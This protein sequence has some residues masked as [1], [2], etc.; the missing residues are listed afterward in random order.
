MPDLSITDQSSTTH[1]EPLPEEDNYLR[2]LTASPKA[3][4]DSGVHIN[5]SVPSTEESVQPQS[6][7]E[8]D[9]GMTDETENVT[10]RHDILHTR[11]SMTSSLSSS[12]DDSRP[13]QLSQ[14]RQAWPASQGAGINSSEGVSTRGASTQTHRPKQYLVRPSFVLD[15]PEL[16]VTDTTSSDDQ[17]TGGGAT[18]ERRGPAKSRKGE[19]IRLILVYIVSTAYM[20]HSML[21]MSTSLYKCRLTLDPPKFVSYSTL[22]CTRCDF[23]HL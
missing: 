5:S 22:E 4:P 17:S 23:R 2:I 11:D 20:Y 9:G 10:G 3:T 15:R 21:L 12:N 6:T 18:G 1:S 14:S 13:H 19:C 8:Y 7:Q 16:T